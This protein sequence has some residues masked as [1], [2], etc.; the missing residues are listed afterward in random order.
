MV[1]DNRIPILVENIDLVRNSFASV[2][3]EFDIVAGVVLKDHIHVLLKPKN[4]H[5]IPNIIGFF[6]GYFTKNVGRGLPRQYK[7]VWQN[8]YYDHIIRNEQDLNRHLDY[9]HFNPTK[10]YSIAPKDWEYS[11]FKK[12][13]K[14]GFYDN[15]WCNFEDKNHI[16]NLDLE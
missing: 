2:K 12:F 3:Y 15:E 5:D 1:T 4:M 7:K 14:L 10:H 11:S 8:R 13:V 6:K 16:E 9:I